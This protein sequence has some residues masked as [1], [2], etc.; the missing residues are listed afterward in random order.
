ML[1]V[2]NV[3]HIHSYSVLDV[4]FAST[5]GCCLL[6]LHLDICLCCFILE[7]SSSGQD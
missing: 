1:T 2:S 5:L 4:A 7:I 6:S 3:F